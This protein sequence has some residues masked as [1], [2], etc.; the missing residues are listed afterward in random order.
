MSYRVRAGQPSDAGRLGAVE[1]AAARRFAEIGLAEISQ[2][3]PT[4]EAG[5]LAAA[6]AG[7]LWVLEGPGGE[8][9][10]LA[11]AGVVDAAGYLAEVSVMPAQAGQRLARLLIAAVEDWAEGQGVGALT[12]TTFKDVPWNRPY[13]E[14]LGFMVLDEG[15]AGP[16]L[17]AIRQKERSRGLDR[18]SPRVSMQ[19]RIGKRP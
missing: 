5:Y 7:Q 19:K 9:V 6:A 4:S 3:R 11:I 1:R 18:I 14:R 15:E 10:G 17:Q 8:V 2:G 16:E 12:L 13:Y